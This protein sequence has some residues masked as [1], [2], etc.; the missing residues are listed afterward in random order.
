MT[1]AD[2][3]RAALRQ[4]W[5]VVLGLLL[6]LAGGYLVKTAPG[7]YVTSAGIYLVA[8]RNVNNGNAYVVDDSVTTVADLVLTAVDSREAR[9][10]LAAAGVRDRYTLELFNAGDQFVPIYDRPLLQ[11]SVSGS[12]PQSVKRTVALVKARVDAE[13]R[14]RQTQTHAAPRIWVRAQLTPADPP[15]VLGRGS[16]LRGVAAVLVIGIIGTG[17]AV[18]A[19][20]DRRR[21]RAAARPAGPELAGVAS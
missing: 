9:A 10:E 1:F 21:R 17:I 18:V 20:D 19:V 8:P 6:T 15:V 16:P 3:A 5:I 13:L 11:L 2:L 4:R 14:L 7:E 12:D